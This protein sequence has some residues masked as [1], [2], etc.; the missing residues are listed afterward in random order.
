MGF[1][2]RIAKGVE[3]VNRQQKGVLVEKMLEHYDGGL[4]G[5]TFALW[6]LAFKPNTDDMRE[7]PSRTVIDRLLAEQCQGQGL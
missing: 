4:D 7:A 6:G 3:V 5:R 1:E 2:T